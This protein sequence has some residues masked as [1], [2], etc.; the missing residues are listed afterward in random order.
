[1]KKIVTALSVAISIAS[2]FFVFSNQVKAQSTAYPI[3]NL[4]L[5]T[6][7]KTLLLNGTELDR[8]GR[9]KEYS[10]DTLLKD[11]KIK[12]EHKGSSRG[13]CE[14]P[15]LNLSFD[16]GKA[17]E[18]F[19]GVSTFDGATT[20]QYQKIRLIPE[21][22]I[23]NDYWKSNGD[24][25][26]SGQLNVSL[27][28]YIIFKI[29][30]K[31]GIPTADVVGFANVTFVAPDTGY[32]GKSFR[33]IIVQRPA[34]QD[35]QIPFTTQFN[36][37]PSLYESGVYESS[38]RPW[39]LDYSNSNRLTQAVLTKIS[40]NS[41]ITIPFDQDSTIKFL[42]LTDFLN[43]GDM[44][45]LHNED[46]GIDWITGKAKLIP[47]GF[48][49]SF[50]C[51]SIDPSDIQIINMINGLPV[52]SRSSYQ[53]AFY[54]IT[55][56]IFGNS[57]SLNQ[58][59][60]LVND[61]PYKDV[62]KEKLIEYL[63]IKFYQYAKYFNSSDFASSINQTY[64]SRS[65]V[66]P[67]TSDEEYNSHRQT[68]FSSCYRT[69]KAVSGLSVSMIGTPTFVYSSD[70]NPA[71]PCPK[72]FDCTG[73]PSSGVVKNG[74]VSLVVEVKT[75]DSA[76]Q[77]SKSRYGN[78]FQAELVGTSGIDQK[79]IDFEYSPISGNIED[80]AGP[81]YSIPPNSTVRFSLS[82]PIN[83]GELLKDAYYIQ[84]NSFQP[85][86]NVTP[87]TLEAKT[88]SLDLGYFDPIEIISPKADDKLA[89]GDL[90]QIKWSGTPN[91]PM[92]IIITSS[93]R[94]GHYISNPDNSISSSENT[95]T[96][97]VGK[98]Y[99]YSNAPGGNGRGSWEL[100]DID[101]GQYKISLR[102]R[103]TNIGGESNYFRINSSGTSTAPS[104]N[105][106]GSSTL[107]LS[108]DRPG[109]DESALIS[110]F[111]IAVTAGNRS[112]KIAKDYAIWT[113]AKTDSDIYAQALSIQYA[114]PS[115]TTDD[116]NGFYIIPANTT[117]I[118]N[119][120]TSFNIKNM[121]A[122]AYY[123]VLDRI[124]LGD[125]YSNPIYLTIPTPNTTNTVVVVGEKSP[126]INSVSPEKIPSNELI[127]VSGARFS[128]VE[129]NT[130]TLSSVESK[131]PEG[132]ACDSFRQYLVSSK[133]GTSL[134]FIP[135]TVPDDY[136]VQVTHPKTGASNIARISISAP[137]M[138]QSVTPDKDRITSGETVT[139]NYEVPGGAVSTKLFLHCPSGVT[140]VGGNGTDGTDL[141]NKWYIFPNTS[142]RATEFSFSSKADW[143]QYVV[144]NF[145]VY[146]KDNPNYAVG[147]TSQITILPSPK[148]I[149]SPQ[150]TSSSPESLIV[151]ME[152]KP[153]GF[154][155]RVI[156]RA[157]NT[158]S[159]RVQRI[160]ESVVSTIS[161]T[162]SL[163]VGDQ[164]LSPVSSV[165]PSPASSATPTPA[166]SP[167]S[168]PTPS[169]SVVARSSVSP[170][171]TPTP[172]NCSVR[173]SAC[174]GTSIMERTISNRDVTHPW[175]ALF[176]N[177]KVGECDPASINITLIL[178]NAS[179][180]EYIEHSGERYYLIGGR[181]YV[182]HSL[183]EFV[184]SNEFRLYDNTFISDPF[185]INPLP[186]QEWSQEVSL[187]FTVTLLKGPPSLPLSPIFPWRI[188]SI[189]ATA[190][191]RPSVSPSPGSTPSAVVPTP[192]PP[193]L[194]PMPS[195]ICP[196][197]TPT[198]TPT[199][200]PTPTPTPTVTITPTV[201]PT[202]SPT[203]SP[204]TS[205][206]PTP[207]VTVTPTV[208]PTASPTVSP[209]VT[210]TVSPTVSPTASPTTT[211]TPTP[212]ASPE[213]S[214]TPEPDPS[215]SPEPDPSESP[216][217]RINPRNLN[218]SIW[219]A[220]AAF[221]G[222]K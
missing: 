191:P 145:Y 100:V 156:S 214:P 70:S 110:T 106:V 48:D 34:E 84:M 176:K 158:I 101:P 36:L 195:F 109:G 146:F 80:Y 148:A 61:F 174:T 133:D 58:M 105:I 155:S 14:P 69:A 187:E 166:V 201:S 136:V 45:Y 169:I 183:E 206:T 103:N 181:W 221:F 28:E 76:V 217:T 7:S 74:Q 33:Y 162:V 161:S 131:C 46:W 189:T 10:G 4:T 94:G 77:M 208:S 140:S 205:P 52:N 63:K 149:P 129:K 29:F 124:M 104:V 138:V 82:A 72:G 47:H 116:G 93:D 141:C 3:R 139:L 49:S 134:E 196:S 123:G 222:L 108:Y 24:T 91:Q 202:V 152:D 85:N 119:V 190:I 64:E 19:T 115:G 114:Q 184:A 132:F 2:V 198:P 53:S 25:G 1:M 151:T 22:D 9:L 32:N 188:D 96:W 204:T 78:A 83:S 35:D 182:I 5:D 157:Q 56:E 99:E 30:R 90:Y 107:S 27:R 159:S 171:P 150:A 177:S 43:V 160:T 175:R 79:D 86:N 180:L 15:V 89:F 26:F 54:R 88:G 92:E 137:T 41:K 38:A 207:T 117:A 216:V 147:A 172:I 12:Y 20:L 185:A 75:T 73:A 144:P 66:L 125:Y 210:P 16:K 212:S 200:T 21:C 153:Q 68:F 60:S 23:W 118:F 143:P 203:I 65:V 120:S 97:E 40:D 13:I 135:N 197:P 220:I 44:D 211:T 142:I 165:S 170:T 193:S 87:L 42:L 163:I 71:V 6:L 126:Y 167:G 11:W 192:T 213:S 218:S 8:D 154:L 67:F 128:T 37:N 111:N 168:T 127:T 51:F 102:Y 122:G 59:I 186:D 112:Q 39:N 81:Y 113:Y 62:D 199:A 18:Y 194:I 219:D 57:T 209:T 164:N 121:F 215:A 55:K 173:R 179:L 17:K 178:D 98:V 31:F 95:N 50:S 130:V